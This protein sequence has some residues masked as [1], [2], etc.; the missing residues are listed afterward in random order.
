MLARPP[1][2]PPLACCVMM[3]VGAALGKPG[4]LVLRDGLGKA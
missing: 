4:Q 2:R 3:T 1:P